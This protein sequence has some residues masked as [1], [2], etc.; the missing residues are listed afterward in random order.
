MEY[1]VTVNVVLVQLHAGT[2]T[3]CQKFR[4]LCTYRPFCSD[5]SPFGNQPKNW[6]VVRMSC[7][8]H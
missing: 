7:S 2:V 1:R 8:A 5:V 6:K 4:I 3:C